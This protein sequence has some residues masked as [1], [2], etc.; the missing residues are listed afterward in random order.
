M[1][2]LS[3]ALKSMSSKG[4]WAFVIALLCTMPALAIVPNK[5]LFDATKAQQ[6]GNADWVIDGDPSVQRFPFPDQSGITASTPETYWRGAL[7]SWG[8]ELVKR[9]FQVETLPPG[10][11]ITFNDASNP[12]DLNNYGVYIVDEP[13]INFTASERA[14]IIAFVNAGGGLFAIS[15]H[16]ASDRNNDGIDSVG[17][18]NQLPVS[19]FGF[20]ITVNNVSPNSTNVSTDPND[21]I[22]RGPAGNA[23]QMIYHNGATINATGQANS[24]NVRPAI[25][26][27]ATNPASCLV[28]Y[29]TYGLGRVV[30]LGDSSPVDD[31]TGAPGDNL[32]NGWS[33]EAGGAHGRL[34][35][36]ATLWLNPTTCTAAVAGTTSPSSPSVAVGQTIMLTSVG[37][38][39]GTLSYQWRRNT[40][41][42]SNGGTYSGVTTSTLSITPQSL[43]DA[44][45][46]DVVVTN[47]CGTSISTPVTLS[48]SCVTTSVTS[49]SPT[50]QTARTTLP[51]SLVGAGAG[52]GPLTY[53]WTRDNVLV[54]DAP[55]YSGATT[56]T[57]SINATS[58]SASGSYVL[59]VGGPCGTADSS[60]V[61]LTVYC[62]G[63]FNRNGI[64]EV[65]DIF[66][67]LSAWFAR[68]PEADLNGS[69]TDVADIF[70]FLAAWFSPCS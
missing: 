33:G 3:R 30:A 61:Q 67:F 48:V 22:I 64:V 20:T 25:Y 12:Q 65:Q 32:F 60:A 62:L 52:S 63:D 47:S 45:S 14:A 50:V 6:A 46:Y 9:G 24:A 21:P 55:P 69:G 56:A 70:Q 41:P 31:G 8:V 15:D 68:Q 17:I 2:N 7:S 34:A 44:G 5:V 66:A 18:W 13:N 36:N 39:T 58:R 51:I 19:T 28:V 29:T 4:L 27:G 40:V 57:L 10:A 42:I 35:I 38:G 11:R 49:P 53:S 26:S 43:A 23:L 54:T 59:T 37:T 16:N 1:L